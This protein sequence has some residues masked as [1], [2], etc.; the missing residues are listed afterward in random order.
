[1]VD[2]K[3]VTSS[4][5]LRWHVRRGSDDHLGPSDHEAW[6]EPILLSLLPAGGTFVDVG[7]HVGHWTVRLGRKAGKVVA[8]E[9]L[10]EARFLLRSNLDSNGLVAKTTVHALAAW[11]RM[12][13]LRL[14]APGDE[15]RIANGSTYAYPDATGEVLG[16]PLDNYLVNLSRVDLVKIDIEGAEAHALR[17]MAQTLSVHRPEVVVEMHEALYPDRRIRQRCLEALSVFEYR[18]VPLKVIEHEA[19]GLIEYWLC[20]PAER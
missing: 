6:L 5:G 7:A 9:P 16:V 17:G 18:V 4:D 20:R 8:F 2:T 13:R 14:S 12:E 3:R 15:F 10:D 11:D 1:M 19:G